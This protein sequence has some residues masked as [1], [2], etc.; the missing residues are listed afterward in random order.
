MRH[1][2]LAREDESNE[3]EADNER[4][5]QTTKSSPEDSYLIPVGTT[6]LVRR[7]GDVIP[8]VLQR[9][10]PLDPRGTLPTQEYISLATPKTCPACGSPVDDNEASRTSKSIGKVVRCGGPQL[11]CEPRAI[12]LLVHAFS[13]DAL[14]VKGL[15]ESRI[16]VLK[17]EGLLRMPSDLFY[18]ATQMESDLIEKLSN[19]TGWGTKSATNLAETAKRVASEGVPLSKFIYSLGIRYLGSGTSVLVAKAYQN[20]DAFLSEMDQVFDLENPL[21]DSFPTLR[22]D[23]DTTKGVGPAL[24]GSLTKYA[25]DLSL[26]DSARKLRQSILVLEEQTFQRHS[27]HPQPEEKTSSDSKSRPLNG[28]LVVFTGAIAGLSRARAQEIAIR[29]GA[30]STPGTVTSQTNALVLGD[31]GGKKLDKAKQL[32]VRIIEGSEFLEMVESFESNRK[33]MDKTGEDE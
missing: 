29:M 8:Q 4:S 2:L 31:K 13:R 22:Q 10:G 19:L 14:Y 15:S 24:L 27:L 9:V 12:G 21:E 6:V 20:A 7:A 25:Q 3:E 32:G 28:M 26:V 5:Q 23:T 16:K 11:L 17:Q 1:I 30:K 18:N 33:G